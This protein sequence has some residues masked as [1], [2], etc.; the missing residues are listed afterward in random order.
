MSIALVKLGGY[1]AEQ[2]KLHGLPFVLLAGAVWWFQE[3]NIILEKAAIERD[4]KLE[5]CND[6]II[7]AYQEN[8]AKLLD[9]IDRN[10]RAF[11]DLSRKIDK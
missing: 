7:A 4:A 5:L 2:L 10:S 6:K 1:L 3:K 9:V 8:Q 11:N